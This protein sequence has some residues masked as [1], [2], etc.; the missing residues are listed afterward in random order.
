MEGMEMRRTQKVV[1]PEAA[2]AL[3]DAVELLLVP[4]G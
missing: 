1:E 3:L 4:A 2:P